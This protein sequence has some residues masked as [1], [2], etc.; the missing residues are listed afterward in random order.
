M[1]EVMFWHEFKVS[2]LLEA[3]SEGPWHQAR[4]WEHK[5]GNRRVEDVI[6]LLIILVMCY[7]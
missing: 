6:K 7:S 3:A 4:E 5:Q 2:L 1:R